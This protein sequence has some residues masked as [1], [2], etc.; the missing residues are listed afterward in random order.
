MNGKNYLTILLLCWSVIVFG[1]NVQTDNDL[2]FRL[3]AISNRDVDFFNIDGIEITSQE[4]N[5]EFTTKNI[6]KKFRQLSVKAKEL[7]DADS[8]LGYKNFY[9]FKSIEKPQGIHNNMSYYFI[10]SG[11]NKIIGIT[12]TAINKMDKEFERKFVELIKN[13]AIPKSLYTLPQIDSINFAGRKIYLGGGACRWMGVN[14]VQCPYYGQMDWSVHKDLNDAEQVVDNRFISIE[15]SGKGKIISNTMEDV[16]FEGVETKARKVVFDF[17]GIRSVLL[18]LE[19]GKTL[20][21]YFIACP[22]RNNYVSCVM[23]F[24]NNDQ[25]NP[26]G[27]PPLLEEVMQLKQ[28]KQ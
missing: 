16:I 7:T 14:N 2:F 19:G 21:I 12:F 25:I 17:T 23:S 10:E 20:T 9:V 6:S 3:Q 5:A 13:K 15:K 1:Q 11:E 28:L 4:V 24:W 18:S 8:M 22:V 27:L 26:S